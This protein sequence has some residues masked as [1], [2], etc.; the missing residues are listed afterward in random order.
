MLHQRLRAVAVVHVPVDD[1]N[2]AQAMLL[3]GP[4]C[5]EGDV[6]EQ[7]EAHAAADGGVMSRRP[8]GAKCV[9]GLA[10]DDLV[11]SQ[12]ARPRR[13]SAGETRGEQIAAGGGFPIEHFA[14]SK[15]S[16]HRFQHEM[17]V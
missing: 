5:G 1:Q 10:A 13:A 6:V 4:T 8:H 3:L 9:F 11:G 14:A 7:A 2:P 15:Y 17:V 12:H 16:I